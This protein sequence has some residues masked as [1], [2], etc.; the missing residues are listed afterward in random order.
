MPRDNRRRD[1]VRQQH[2]MASEQHAGE[3]DA[4]PP[5]AEQRTRHADK[6]RGSPREVYSQRKTRFGERDRRFRV[7]DRRGLQAAVQ[8]KNGRN[9]R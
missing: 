2:G 9:R 8:S 7:R 3:S 1:H 4:V 5:E 6:A